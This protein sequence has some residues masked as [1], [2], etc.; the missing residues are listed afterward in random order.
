MLLTDGKCG[1]DGEFE[2]K[3]FVFVETT[4][5]VLE[6]AHSTSRSIPSTLYE[7]RS[8]ILVTLTPQLSHA[9]Q[10][11]MGPDTAGVGADEAG[12]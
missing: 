8:Q 12:S 10:H 4:T 11:R 6:T 3:R 7:T 5:H 2:Y 1:G 9:L